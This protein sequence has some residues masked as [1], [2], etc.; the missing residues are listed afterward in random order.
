MMFSCMGVTFLFPI[1]AFFCGLAIEHAVL[2]HRSTFEVRR[3]VV[4]QRNMNE[5][6]DKIEDLLNICNTADFC[7]R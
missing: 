5:R 6:L 2:G 7:L 4:F 1:L 3:V